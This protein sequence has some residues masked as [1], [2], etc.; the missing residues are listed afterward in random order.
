MGTRPRPR[1]AAA[2]AAG[3]D[4]EREARTGPRATR[5]RCDTLA[6]AQLGRGRPLTTLQPTKR[7]PPTTGAVEQSGESRRQC[8]R[9][10][11]QLLLELRNSPNRLRLLGELRSR[12]CSTQKD[13]E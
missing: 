2:A 3:G 7:Q 11:G 1:Q 4:G 9:R 10:R 13:S 8:E 12:S 6:T 5:M